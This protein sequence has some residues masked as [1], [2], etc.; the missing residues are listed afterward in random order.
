MEWHGRVLFGYGW[1][2]CVVRV[3]S[4][5]WVGVLISPSAPSVRH[6]D[7]LWSSSIKGEGDWW[8]LSPRPVDVALKP[9]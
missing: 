5:T 3:Q 2:L 8:V 1:L 6:W 7:R 4:I 9:V